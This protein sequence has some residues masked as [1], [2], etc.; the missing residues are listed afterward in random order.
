MRASTAA[1]GL[2]VPPP[3]VPATPTSL[4][5]PSERSAPRSLLECL[6]DL[7]P[8]LRR[9][10]VD[11]PD[12][13]LR[14]SIAATAD[15]VASFLATEPADLVAPFRLAN[16][17]TQELFR[18]ADVLGADGEEMRRFGQELLG[19]FLDFGRALLEPIRD[20]FLTI[21]LDDYYG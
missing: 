6:N 1:L 9:W 15:R 19:W 21:W 20:D 13:G 17:L 8:H 18:W 11:S 2:P 12:V 4:S 16:D 10:A 7:L 5:P 3:D 14:P